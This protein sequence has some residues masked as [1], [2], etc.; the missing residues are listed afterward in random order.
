M[1]YRV[2]LRRP[3]L[4]AT[5]TLCALGSASG[6]FAAQASAATVAANQ[7]CYVNANP[8][9]GAPM[10]IT[11]AGFTPGDTVD[12]SGGTVFAEATVAADGSFA[13]AT[14]APILGT[15]DPATQST[16]LTATDTDGVTASIPVLSANLAVTATPSSVRHPD[17]TKVTFKFSGFTP[18]RHIYAY[19]LHNKK[20]VAT[21]KFGTAAGAC[22][23]FSQKALLYPG[24]HPRYDQY[25]VAFESSSRY[26]KT[27]LPQAVA[28]LSIFSF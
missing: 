11:G 18:G 25:K 17:R 8:S 16:T 13:V 21:Q 20:L 24:G 7:P 12:V 14:Q 27:A 5:T 15:I 4:L 26:S 6:A 19:Y 10:T 2:A 28:K 22:G 3:L 23:T 9:L 1:S